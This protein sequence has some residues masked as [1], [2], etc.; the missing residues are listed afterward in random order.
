MNR[1]GKLAMSY[2]ERPK[3][4]V[5]TPPHPKDRWCRLCALVSSRREGEIPFDELT[6]AYLGDDVIVLARRDAHEVMAAPTEHVLSL[7][8]LPT[9]R[10]AELLATLRRVA[11]AVQTNENEM[12]FG[13]V[14]LLGATGHVCVRV[15]ADEQQVL[16]LLDPES[17]VAHRIRQA[18]RTA[19][20]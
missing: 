17:D 11:I 7:S 18:V 13:T 10:M 14:S 3:E 15:A 8:A 5:I 6:V 4:L 19:P 12:G 16:E 20:T 2:G 9:A 1:S